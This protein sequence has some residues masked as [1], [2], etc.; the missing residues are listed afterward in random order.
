[1]SEPERLDEVGRW[2]G[3]AGEDLRAARALMKL[4]E[5]VGV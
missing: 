1:M 4:E 2:L 5:F 3:Y